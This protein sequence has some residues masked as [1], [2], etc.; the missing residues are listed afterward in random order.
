[1]SLIFSY[2]KLLDP[3]SSVRE[4][5][6][7]NAQNTGGVPA[8][9]VN[10]YNKARNGRFLTDQQKADFVG[11]SEKL[12]QAH[13]NQVAP[14]F[15]RYRGLAAKGGIDPQDVAEGQPQ[16]RGRQVQNPDGKMYEEGPDG[17]M[18]EVP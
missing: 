16:A 14:V 8:A 2:M 18:R 7:A 3:G 5:E 13:A 4:G 6:Y 1:M 15:E 17:Q 12:Y 11:E 9:I 10:M